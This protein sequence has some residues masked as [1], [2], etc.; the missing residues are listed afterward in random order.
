MTAHDPNLAGE[1]RGILRWL[2]FGTA[3]QS[4]PEPD[5]SKGETEPGEENPREK[6]RR[7]LLNDVG[8]FLLTHRLEVNTYT[9][10]IA[11]DVITGADQRIARSARS[12]TTSYKSALEA[13]VDELEQVSR[14]GVVITDLATIARVMLER[15]REIEKEMSRSEMQTLALQKSLDEARRKADMDHL[16][17]LPNRRAFETTLGREIAAALEN[18]EPLCVAFVDVHNFKKINDLH[19]HE[20]GDRVLKAVAQTLAR[21]SD[22]R[23]HVARHGGEEFVVV[24]RG[25]TL[26][27]AWKILDRAREAMAGRRLVNRATDVPFGRIT[28]SGG[29]ADLFAYPGQS[30]ALKAADDALYAAKAGGR[31]VILR[32][33]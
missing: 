11:H 3:T 19:G 28:F 12:A 9:L 20:S 5:E 33:G 14:A 21:I 32:A 6:R 13:H 7:Q 16:T 10:A 15:T 30:E 24:L 25:R 2:G 17:G 1:T 4:G 29:I 8:S 27:E 26:D 31:N 18:R 22:D 23:C